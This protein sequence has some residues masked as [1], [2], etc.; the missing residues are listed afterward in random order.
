M[1]NL[2]AYIADAKP[3]DWRTNNCAHFAAGW[4]A[5]CRGVDPLTEWLG[6]MPS[7]RSALRKLKQAGGYMGA[8]AAVL[9]DYKDGLYAQRG[10]VVLLDAARWVHADR[11]ALGYPTSTRARVGIFPTKYCGMAWGICTGNRI[12][13]LGKDGVLMLPMIAARA[14]WRV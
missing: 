13:A 8:T 4:V 3:F 14:A 1:S 2:D 9:G 7:T 10:D 12:A 11:R 6:V 5:L